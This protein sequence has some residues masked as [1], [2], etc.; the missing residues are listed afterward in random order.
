MTRSLTIALVLVGLGTATTLTSTSAA[1]Q[2]PATDCAAVYG[3]FRERLD[4]LIRPSFVKHQY[5]SVLAGS[6]ERCRA[7]DPAAW[8]RIERILS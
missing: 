6:Y 8:D 3:Q 1:A 4:T 2:A 7:S 5:E